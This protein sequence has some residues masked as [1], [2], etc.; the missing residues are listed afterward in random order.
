MAEDFLPRK[1]SAPARIGNAYEFRLFAL[2][3][4]KMLSDSSIEHVRHEDSS[5]APADDVIIEFKDRIE[6]FQAKHA[7]NP[8]A[9]LEIDFAAAE[10]VDKATGLHISLAKLGKAWHSLQRKAKTII[11]RIFTNRAAGAELASFLDGDRFKDEFVGN[12]WQKQKRKQVQE[13]IQE[14]IELS[15]D[16]LVSFLGSLRYDL[17]QPNEEGLD[18]VIRSDWLQRRFGLTSSGVYGRFLA[19]AERWYLERRSRPIYRDEIL[20]ALQIDNSTLP[21]RFPIDLKTYV[22]RPN[23]EQEV[24]EVLFRGESTYTAIVGTPGSGKSTFITRFT[25]ELRRRGQPIIRYYAFTQINDPL[26]R[27]RVTAQ[28]FLKSMIE[29]LCQEFRNLIP[30]ERR[31]DYSESRLNELLTLLGSHFKLRGQQLLIVVDGIDHVGRAEI[32][33]TQKLLNVLP[34]HLPTGVVCLIGT[35]SIGYLPSVIERQCQEALLNIPLFEIEQTHH[36]LS[37]YFDTSSRPKERTVGAIHKRSEGL[38]LY[39]RFIAERLT[40]V[41]IEEYDDL[42]EKLPP[43]EG[44][45]DSYY[46]SLWSEFSREPKLKK[47]CGLAARLYFRVQISDLLSMAE[48]TDAFE[49]EPLFNRMKHLMQVSDAGCRVFHNSFRDFIRTELLPEQLQQLDESI[50]FS[51]LDKQ[52]NQLLWFMYAHRY[53]EAAK[54]YGY[55]MTNYGQSYISEAIRRG[56]PRNEIIEALQAAARAAISERNLVV[57][58]CSAALLSHTQ[59]RLEH[60]LDRTQLWRTLLSMGEI[61]D[62]LAAFA[63]EREV[64]DL[65]TETARIIVHLAERG[66]YEFG[67]ALAQDFL[68]RLPRQIEGEDYAVAI[69]ELISVYAPR[70]AATLARWIGAEPNPDTSLSY[71]RVDLGTALLPK[72]LKNLY[73]FNRWNVLRILRRLLPLQPGWEAHRDRWL[74]EIIKLETEFRPN[75]VCY[76]VRNASRHIQKQDERILLAGHVAQHDLGVDIVEELLEGIILHPQLERESSFSLRSQ[77]FEVFRAYVAGLEYLGRYTEL[78][79]LGNFLRTSDS[80]VAAYYQV[81]YA[82]STSNNQPEKLLSA[83]THFAEHERRP[84]EDMVNIKRAVTG[85]LLSLL[86]ALINRYLLGEGEV[87]V[88]LE[89]FRY[90]AEEKTFSIPKITGLQVLSAFPE[91]R[92]YLQSLLVE[93]HDH[94]FDTE[95]ETQ[96]RTNELLSIAELACQCGHFSLGRTWLQEAV[97]ALRGYGY[98]KDPTVG[99]L[100]EALEEVSSLQPELFRQRIADIAEWNL[101]ITEFTDGKT[102]KWFPISLYKT[103]IRHNP[104]VARELLLTYRNH[105]A[106]WK[107]SD[108]MASFITSYNGGNLVLA[109]TLSELIQEKGFGYED[110]YKDKFEARLHLLKVAVERG[111]QN[112]ANWM[113]KRIRQFLLTEVPP[114]ERPFLVETFNRYAHDSNLSKIEYFSAYPKSEQRS[115]TLNTSSLDINPSAYVELNGKQISINDLPRKLSTSPENFMQDTEKLLETH[116]IYDFSSQL[117]QAIELLLRKTRSIL[118]LNQLTHLLKN[119]QDIFEVCESSLAEAYVRLGCPD[120]AS[121]YYKKV[122]MS[123]NKHELWSPNMEDFEKLAE[124]NSDKALHTLFEFVDRHIRNYSWGGE[125]I[126]LIFIKGTLAIGDN[127]HQSAIELYKSFHEFVQN[128]FEHLPTIFSSPYEWLRDP[129]HQIRSFEEIAKRLIEQAWSAPLLHRRQHLVHLLKDL[130]LYQPTSTLPWLV[131]LLQH[132]DYTLNKQSALVIASIALDRPTMLT[133]YVDALIAALDTPHAERIYYLKQTLEVIANNCEKRTIIIDKVESLRPRIAGT[134]LVILPDTLR[135]SPYFRTQTLARTARSIRETINTICQGLDFDLDKLHWQIEQEIEAMGFD[136]EVAKQEFNERGQAYC[137]NIDN[138]CIPFETYDDYYVW[139][140]FNRVLER[141]LRENVVHPSAQ[142]AIDALVRLY[143]SR[144]PF[145]EIAPKPSDVNVPFVHKGYGGEEL[146]EEARAWLNFE[147]EEVRKEQPLEDSWIVV[148]DEYYQQAGRMVEKRLSTSFLA[149]HTLADTILRGDWRVRSGEAILR[150]APEPPYYSLTIDEARYCLEQS[151][152]RISDDPFTTI[153]LVS[154]HWGDW[155]HFTRSML[156][157]IAG[158]WIRRYELSWECSNSLNLLFNGNSA[159]KLFSWC[160]GFEVGYNRRNQVGYGTRL[161]LSKEFLQ[162]LMQDYG[163]CLVVT[164]WSKRSANK[165][166]VGKSHEV[167]FEQE[168]EAVSIYRYHN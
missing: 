73:T 75:T 6:C 86:T 60:Y 136:C 108:S 78:Q 8:H 151:Q 168:Q 59:D 106:E 93:I 123:K 126:F 55:L 9:L 110:S 34:E 72:A 40:Q 141:E 160:D 166:T 48:V 102:T 80:S 71:G 163:L 1:I 3:C 101:L 41:P 133:E 29:Q 56:R 4:L 131:G 157:S 5:A 128:Q 70:A 156:A 17:R 20:E 16:E 116:K 167:E 85:D 35:Q 111:S 152:T 76:H 165:K 62:A 143:D 79:V 119:R 83:L 44:H 124:I 130:A 45:I 149:S 104:E 38:P 68:D 74:L 98:R 100:I 67:R 117:Q 25:D 18:E 92:G 77:E 125:T 22:A 32:D 155:W 150:L 138:D 115:S 105:I 28:A 64:Y 69:G 51:Y 159:Q 139:H 109:Y 89:R 14:Y 129:N 12:T 103:I 49:G 134:N 140:A 114:T 132:E 33:K 127:Y 58:A 148:V 146:T 142:M 39:L 23:F 147:G 31:Y 154:I 65:S 153:P 158:E 96:S 122:F 135:P 161:L 57:T 84:G 137:S 164:G 2:S 97:I 81:C 47:L 88:L 90:A 121:E 13:K 7:M 95:L 53:A 43:H 99:L 42:V 82:V 63:Q 15:D 118:E 107:F 54:A 87:N 46:S 52:R 11:I 27:E 112:V 36:F 37:R 145:I 113:E 24:L 61:N 91:I 30:D 162:T 94:I 21:Q 66:E 144:F 26:Q 120:K 19:H 10:L 50:L